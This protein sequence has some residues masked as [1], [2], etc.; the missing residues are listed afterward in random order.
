[1]RSDRSRSWSLAWA[2]ILAAGLLA[3]LLAALAPARAA[4]A[5][6]DQAPAP[7]RVVV[8]AGHGG[9]DPGAI[10]TV[11]PLR[12]KD[13][14]LKLALLTGAALQRR[15]IGVIYTR[16]DDT[17]V[18]LQERAALA[19]RTGSSLLLSLHLNSAPD[20]GVSGAEAWYGSGPRDHDLAG[21]LLSGVA[22]A[23]REVNLA[24]RGTRHGP[25]LA[26]LQGGVPAALIEVGYV[27]NRR[28]AALLLQPSYLAKLAE[29]LAAGIARYRDVGDSGTLRVPRPSVPSLPLTDLY[30]IRPG[31]S[32]QSIASRFRT[33]TEE[34]VRLNTGLDMQ[35]LL[36]GD[37]LTVPTGEAVVASWSSGSPASRT[38][39]G[40]TAAGA[41]PAQVPLAASHVVQAGDT[42]SGI[43]LRYGLAASDLARWNGI[44]DARLILVGQ[45]IRLRPGT[46]QAQAAPSSAAPAAQGVQAAR[47]Y[48]VQAGDTL[49]GIALR[50]AVSLDALLAANALSNPN[51]VLV[52]T[53][54][55]IPARM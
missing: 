38:A 47:R 18:P 42:L 13:V 36:P 10:S 35:R 40:T 45:R 21:A 31:D 43:A 7:F 14:T 23:M 34:I 4:L 28:E 19:G 32:L 52:G 29:G 54:L 9:K 12:E 3:L 2:R 25:S 17:Y 33:A 49:S 11:A 27:S 39:S 46:G 26:V 48:R 24:L 20:S 5:G 44:T 41:R 1:V 53:T 22:P 8:D 55:T 6:T 37:P 16:T 15:G 50:H 30:F 51:H